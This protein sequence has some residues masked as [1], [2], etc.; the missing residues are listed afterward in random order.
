MLINQ[1]I[2]IQ[3]MHAELTLTIVVIFKSLQTRICQQT[4][5]KQKIQS[6]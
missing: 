4:E 6:T 5:S 1:S 2:N 3:N